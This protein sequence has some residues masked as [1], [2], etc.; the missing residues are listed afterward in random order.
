MTAILG[1]ASPIIRLLL[2]AAFMIVASI[3]SAPAAAFDDD[4]VGRA[5]H[6]QDAPAHDCC[7]PEPA[8]PDGSCGLTCVQA[9]CGWTTPLLPAGWSAPIDGQ[10]ARW[11]ALATLGDDVAQDTATPP[12]RA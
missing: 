1:T 7:D 5:L 2:A 3:G 4:H 6:V 9:G 12:P 11:W 8:T 10:T